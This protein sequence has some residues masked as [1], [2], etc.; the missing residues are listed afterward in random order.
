MIN[1]QW[2]VPGGYVSCRMILDARQLRAAAP[3]P[4][5]GRVFPG[6][7]YLSIAEH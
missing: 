6:D 3:L 2:R 1:V 5:P 7:R 4:E